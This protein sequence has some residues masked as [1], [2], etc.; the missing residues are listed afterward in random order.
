MSTATAQ[1]ENHVDW[2]RAL[3]TQ[4]E[5]EVVSCARTPS[6]Q[7][8]GFGDAS[9]FASPL[10]SPRSG[11]S[12]DAG[13]YSLPEAPMGW[14][15]SRIDELNEDAFG[16]GIDSLAIDDAEPVYRS[17]GGIMS[18]AEFEDDPSYIFDDAP[19]MR[20]FGDA[21]ATL[22]SPAGLEEDSDKKWLQSMP[23]LIRRQ[24]AGRLGGGMPF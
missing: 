21:F 3:R 12:T 9:P 19:V 8:V 2:L 18:S 20:G 15:H 5:E 4:Y 1:F 11:V 14:A 16:Y 17:L 13:S 24:K 23:P 6:S 10:S 7:P 22:A